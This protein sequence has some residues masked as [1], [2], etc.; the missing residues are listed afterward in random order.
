M[1]VL[2]LFFFGGQVS[3]QEKIVAG[4]SQPQFTDLILYWSYVLLAITAVILIGFA[5]SDFFK[6]LKESPKKA[7]SGF[8]AILGLAAMLV[9]TF[10]IGDGTPL[11]IPGYDG[12]DNMPPTL[13]MTDMWL[14]SMYIML[15]ITALAIIVMPLF[16]KKR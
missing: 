5:M 16:K 12:A 3:D 11:H 7:L 1:I 8:L 9:I 15:V 10:V 2:G 13:K 6:Q 4:M 14:Y